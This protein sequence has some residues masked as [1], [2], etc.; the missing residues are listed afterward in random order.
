MNNEETMVLQ[1]QNK[2]TVQPSVTEDNN[3]S[4]KDEKKKNSKTAA[5]AAAAVAGG[6][7]GGAGT[8]AATTMMPSDEEDKKDEEDKGKDQDNKDDSQHSS[9][10]RGSDHSNNDHHTAQVNTSSDEPDYTGHAGADPV[11]TNAHDTSTHESA[12]PT[13]IH[14]TGNTNDSDGVQII[15][16]YEHTNDAG[17]H[18]EAAV[19]TDGEEVAIVL[20]NDGDN[21]ADILWVDN[22]HNMAVE[23]GEVIDVSDHHVGMQMYED[24]YIAQQ[25]QVED[26]QH[27]D[28]ASYEEQ[29]QEQQEYEQHETFAYNADDTQDYGGDADYTV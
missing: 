3:K 24:A 14:T 4:E 29:Q 22:N 12:A 15:G 5:V 19:L 13:N 9:P 7:I 6:V 23:E 18:Q 2:P 21:E 10:N 27:V 26:Q 8:A 28:M 20:D 1:D 25:Q 16:V 17:V 11:V